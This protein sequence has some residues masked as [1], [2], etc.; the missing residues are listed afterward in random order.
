MPVCHNLLLS[1]LHFSLCYLGFKLNIWDQLGLC[2][3]NVDFILEARGSY[4][5]ILIKKS[6]MMQFMENG[7]EGS[8]T[9]GRK[10]N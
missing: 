7:L 9:G 5:S 6:G 4:E 3:Q 10:I 1:S 2:V 8:K